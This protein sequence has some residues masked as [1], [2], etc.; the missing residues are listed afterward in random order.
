MVTG[1]FL[2]LLVA[3]VHMANDSHARIA[4]QD[5][6]QAL[7]RFICPIGNDDLTG[8]NRVADTDSTAVV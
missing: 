5:S 4:G 7:R 8:V 2:C 3:G 1:T 6:L